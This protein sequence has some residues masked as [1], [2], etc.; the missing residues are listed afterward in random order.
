MLRI[1]PVPNTQLAT[2][3]YTIVTQMATNS[4]QPQNLVRSAIAPEI[5]AGVMIANISWNIANTSTGIAR[6]GLTVST[7][8]GL[9]RP[10]KS[11]VQP[12]SRS[13]RD[14]PKAIEKP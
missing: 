8:S 7:A 1:Q 4:V 5:S 9:P 6:R 3:K 11:L 10:T 2:G 14:S 13:V 12:I